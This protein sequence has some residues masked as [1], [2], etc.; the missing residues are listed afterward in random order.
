MGLKDL[1]GATPAGMTW[2]SVPFL[3]PI[4]F[5]LP[6][7]PYV[8][9]GPPLTPLGMAAYSLPLLPGEKKKKKKKQAANE[10]CE[11]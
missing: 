9:W 7:P 6:L 3:Y 5:P 11:E 4:N 1:W 2:G 8:G 10:E